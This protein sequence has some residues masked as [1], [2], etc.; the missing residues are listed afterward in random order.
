MTDILPPMHPGEI[1]REEFLVPLNMSAGTLAKRLGVSRTRIERL[2]GERTGITP[3]TALRLAKV[4]NTAP[5]FW[6]NMQASYDLKVHAAALAAD[7][8]AIQQFKAE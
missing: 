2:A 1:L 4:F 8:A 3:D 5:E 7:L 6:M